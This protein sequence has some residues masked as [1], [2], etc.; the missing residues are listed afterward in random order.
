M[1]RCFVISPIGNEDSETREHAND[2]L[3]FIIKPAMEEL[4]I[5]AYRSD[6]IHEVGKISDQMFRSILNDDLCIAVLTFQNPNVYYELAVAQSAARPVVILV[7]KGT[8]LPFDV[9]DMRTV[10]YDLKPRP[11]KEGT[12]VKEIVEKVRH[13]ELE[14]TRRVVPFAPELAPLGG[15]QRVNTYPKAE[16][17]G[18]SNKWVDTL[19]NASARFDLCGISL[20]RWTT[21]AGVAELF[22]KKAAEGCRIRV[23]IMSPD[24][25]GLAG[26]L[27]EESNQG[28]L[29]RTHQQIKDTFHFFQEIQNKH[30]ALEI[31]LLQKATPHQ[32]ILIN[33]ACSLVV[34]YLYSNA[35]IRSPLFDF[36]SDDEFYAVFSTEFEALWEQAVAGD[37]K[38]F[39]G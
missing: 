3:D 31:K 16:E 38:L 7:E 21:V 35:T 20:I 9:K 11:L 23:L 22:A 6:H 14:G 15:R 39:S 32:M 34:P 2:V 1:K 10:Y 36:S 33:D 25:P 19:L 37:E 12:Y 5:E 30:A 8:N 29:A 17:Y 13:L 24:N 26:L 4:G 27:N 28:S 18:A